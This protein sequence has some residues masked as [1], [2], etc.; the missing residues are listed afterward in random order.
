ML[1]IG[2]PFRGSY[3]GSSYLLPP[4]A[5]MSTQRMQKVNHSSP[6]AMLTSGVR[7]QRA[8]IVVPSFAGYPLQISALLECL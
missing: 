5:N 4:L 3:R 1:L 7:S 2:F 8:G 6:I